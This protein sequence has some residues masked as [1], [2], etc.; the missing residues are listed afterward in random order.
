MGRRSKT[1]AALGVASVGLVSGSVAAPQAS[2]HSMPGCGDDPVV[3][4]FASQPTSVRTN[5]LTPGIQQDAAINATL[6]WDVLS[7]VAFFTPAFGNPTVAYSTFSDPDAGL[8]GRAFRQTTGTGSGCRLAS[9][10]P[11]LNL[12]HFDGQPAITTIN[13]KQCIFAHELGHVIGTAHSNNAA[14][15]DT[16]QAAHSSADSI[17]R[18]GEHP[19][20]CHVLPPG[21]PPGGPRTAD[22]ADANFKY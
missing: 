16:P 21:V 12:V 22:I 10:T 4:I 20:R 14:Q 9:G 13:E 11:A 8:A 3:P 18:G 5:L 1:I 7:D 6:A 19:A 15:N 2:A 17:M